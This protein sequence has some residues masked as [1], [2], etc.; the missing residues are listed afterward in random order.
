MAKLIHTDNE[1]IKKKNQLKDIGSE[2]SN[3]G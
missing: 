3:I 2:R 1:L